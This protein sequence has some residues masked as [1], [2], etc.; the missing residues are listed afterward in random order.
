[1][2][3][4]TRDEYAEFLTQ[5]PRMLLDVPI[6][7]EALILNISAMQSIDVRFD[8]PRLVAQAVYTAHHASKYYIRPA[9]TMVISPQA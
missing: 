6:H 2:T 5:Y 1:M 9:D 4:V 7:T 3:E 8:P